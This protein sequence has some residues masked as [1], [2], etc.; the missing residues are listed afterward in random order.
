MPTYTEPW[1]PSLSD[2]AR[3][4]PTRTRDTRTPGSDRLTGTFSPYTTPDNEQAQIC[5]DEAV[6]WV[7][8]RAGPAL[9]AGENIRTAARTAAAWR[10]AADIEIAY[11]QRD[12]DIRLYALLDQRAKDAINDLIQRIE[13]ETGGSGGPDGIAGTPVWQSLPPPRWADRDP[14]GQV[15]E[16]PFTGGSP[17]SRVV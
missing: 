13:R 10:A 4:I 12:A 2:V 3:H 11:P 15:R 1:A 8:G 6:Q 16:R 14:D 7:L 9:P 5:I 17:Y